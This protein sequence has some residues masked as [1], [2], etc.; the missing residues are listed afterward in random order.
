MEQLTTELAMRKQLAPSE[1]VTKDPHNEFFAGIHTDIW[2][3]VIPK[4]QLIATPDKIQLLAPTI[5]ETL[6]TKDF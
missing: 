6:I 4:R 1:V 5:G 3:R 2:K